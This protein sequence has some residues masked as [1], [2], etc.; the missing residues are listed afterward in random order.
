M[1]P[2]LSL[3]LQSID[4]WDDEPTLPNHPNRW[5]IHELFDLSDV[6]TDV[7]FMPYVVLYV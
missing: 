1:R 6:E 4:D 3:I 5:I 2:N 7:E